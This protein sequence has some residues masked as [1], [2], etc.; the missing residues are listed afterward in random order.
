MVIALTVLARADAAAGRLPEARNSLA[1]L[2]DATATSPSVA[3]RIQFLAARAALAR[4]EG[5]FD[6]AR[7]DL[8]DGIAVAVSSQR[9]VDEF[10]LRFDQAEL[11]GAAGDVAK[12]RALAANLS[13]QAASLGL[14]GVAGRAAR[15]AAAAIEGGSVRP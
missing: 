4:A 1:S 15:L 3:R 2:G 8:L 6:D 10:E 7:R 12:C 13:A 9:K 14:G 5:R 11:E